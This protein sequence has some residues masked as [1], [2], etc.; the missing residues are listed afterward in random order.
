MFTVLLI[1][2]LS[3]SRIICGF[4]QLSQDG[5]II[6]Q[7]SFCANIR[8][9]TIAQREFAMAA[10]NGLDLAIVRG[11]CSTIHRDD[12]RL[13][14]DK[15]LL[16][17]G[18]AQILGD[19]PAAQIILHA[20]GLHPPHSW[21]TYYQHRTRLRQTD[22]SLHVMPDPN[23][24]EYITAAVDYLRDLVTHIE[25][26]QYAESIAGYQIAVFEG[27]EFMLPAGYYGFS[28]ATE[29]AFRRWIEQRYGNDVGVLRRAWND[30]QLESFDQITVPSAQELTFADLGPFRNPHLRGRALDFTEFR[31]NANAE[32]LLTLAQT[33]KESSCKNPLTGA[34]YGYLL[35]CNQVFYKGHHALRKV[36]DSPSLDFLAAPYSY[37]YRTPVWLGRP[38]LDIGAGSFHGAVDSIL[39]NNKL[40][41]TEDDSR[42]YLTTDSNL[43]NFSDI[44]GTIANLRR[45]HLA[46][47]TRGSGLWRLDLYGSGW[48]DSTQ[49]MQE[50]GKQ[51][52]I[53]DALARAP[54][55][56]QVYQPDVAVIIDE[57]SARYVATRSIDNAGARLTIDMFLRDNLHRAGVSFGIYLLDDLT[58]GRVPPC[59]VYLFAGTYAISSGARSWIRNNLKKEDRTLIWMY[60]AGLYDETGWGVDKMRSLTELDIVQSSEPAP[61]GMKSAR[62]LNVSGC[63]G[64]A[65]APTRI[66]GFPEWYVRNRPEGGV[67]L[68]HYMHGAE[69][70]PAMVIENKDGWKSMYVGASGLTTAWVRSVMRIT[71]VHRYL[72]S[73]KPVPC[74]IGH[75]IIGIW[76]VNAMNGTIRLKQLSDVYD[77]YSGERVYSKVG[78]FPVKLARWKVS[79]YR[80]DACR[81]P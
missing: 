45:N 26:Q 76:P 72:E 53:S 30:L 42:T 6:A 64:L 35:E 48:Y 52:K 57:R 34:F 37:V 39:L 74:Y 71:G 22:G 77:L 12:G 15:Q 51:K 60:G 80:I 9:N 75:N 4:P 47:L 10:T 27:G 17:Q 61:G 56:Q 1:N 40:F 59:E 21:H 50:L 79:G 23:S 5:E 49:L 70:R 8:N 67:V 69:A 68:A 14:L 7:D 41:F 38:H 43:S 28:D 65:W 24:P 31:Q 18:V 55:Y 81:E 11:I 3:V 20:G 54:E 44:Q 32:L 16:D 36:L 78:H 62:R 33:I 19:N 58:A 73:D 13:T 2:L 46:N 63:G 66:S 29:A 25:K